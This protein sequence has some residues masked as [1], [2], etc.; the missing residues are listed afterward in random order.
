ML[1]IYPPPGFV[2]IS[3]LFAFAGIL[4]MQTLKAQ[5]PLQLAPQKFATYDTRFVIPQYKQLNMLTFST[6]IALDY[7]PLHGDR[8]P[9]NTARGL[10]TGVGLAYSKAIVNKDCQGMFLGL[11]YEIFPGRYQKAKIYFEYKSNYFFNLFDIFPKYELIYV[12]DLTTH[13]MS[14]QDRIYFVNLR[15]KSLNFNFGLQL[16]G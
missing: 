11:G 16:G 7:K 2:K 12:W 1:N 5:N 4:F 14:K 8:G 15:H 13:Q 6:I 10:N 3:L 9:G